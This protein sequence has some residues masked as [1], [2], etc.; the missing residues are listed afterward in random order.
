MR[1]HMDNLTA[2][3]RDSRPFTCKQCGGVMNYIGRGTYECENCKSLEYDDYGKITKY[4]E[5]NG[6]SPAITI[7]RATGIPRERITALLRDGRVEIPNGYNE[8]VYLTCQKCGS[9]IRYGQVCPTCGAAMAGGDPKKMDFGKIGARPA[10][11]TGGGVKKS[12][13]GNLADQLGDGKWR[14]RK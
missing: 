8:S 14:Y 1:K 7:S 6:P 9:R 5:E 10:T 13:Y 2:L 3:L 12:G 4:I 11:G